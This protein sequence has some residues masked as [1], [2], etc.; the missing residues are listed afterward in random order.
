[1]QSVPAL[2]FDLGQRMAT[3]RQ[4]S[5]WTDFLLVLVTCGIYGF[6]IL[7]KLL[8]RRQ[9]HFERMVSFRWHLIEVLRE[10]AQTRTGDFEPDLTELERLHAVATAGDRAGDKTPVVWLLMSIAGFVP[11]TYYAM[12]FLNHDFHNHEASEAAFMSKAAELMGKLQMGWQPRVEATVP[13]R[14]FLGY[15]L[16]T[17]VTFGVYGIYWW[18]TLITDPNRHFGVHSIWEAGLSAELA[19]LNPA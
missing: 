12:N 6:Y 7:Y 18:Y 15:F 13:S 9:Q 14:G 8:E 1:M 17:A 3:D 19:T 5:F 16:L 10:R 4:S 2:S 11:A